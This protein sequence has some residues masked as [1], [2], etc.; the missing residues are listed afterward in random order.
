[1]IGGVYIII[2]GSGSVYEYCI[3]RCESREMYMIYTCVFTCLTL[4]D[5]LKVG[6]R[7]TPKMACMW[8]ICW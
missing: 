7:A 6:V 3:E 1:M 4:F 2:Q 5:N 8:D